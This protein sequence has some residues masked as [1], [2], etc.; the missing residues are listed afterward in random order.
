[1]PER[2]EG[3]KPQRLRRSTEFSSASGGLELLIGL[4]GRSSL[5]HLL[6]QIDEIKARRNGRHAGALF[7]AAGH[8]DHRQHKCE[9]ARGLFQSVFVVR[10]T[11]S[12]SRVLRRRIRE[13]LV[14]GALPHG[15]RFELGQCAVLFRLD[16]PQVLQ[17]LELLGVLG[18]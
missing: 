17:F 4:R 9:S 18:S 14:V 5:G 8:Y 3:S 11:D 1:M 12:L 7:R 10:W 13:D 2:L 16:P 15:Y 6:S